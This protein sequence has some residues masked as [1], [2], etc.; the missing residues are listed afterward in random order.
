MHRPTLVRSLRRLGALTAVTLAVTVATA[1][2][3]AAHAE[4]EAEGARALDQNVALTFSA[5]SESSSAGITKLEVVLPDGITADDITYKE[6]PEDWKLA[7]TSRGYTVSG[8]KLAVGEDA[9]YVVVVRQLPD[10]K[11]LVFKTLQSYSDGRVDRWIELEDNAE[12]DHGHGHGNPAPV[13]QLK[14]AAPG[15]KPVSPSPTQEPTTAAPSPDTASGEPSAGTSEESG[16]AV[17][18]DTDGDGGVPLAVL[19]GIGAAVIVLGG[20]TWWLRSRR[21]GTA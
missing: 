11:E 12:D 4:V 9:E 1:G 17:A 15:A 8:P 3:A 13:L 2:P 18:D 5:A 7:P 6:G 19:L 20:G 14:P 10:A 16:E 21:S